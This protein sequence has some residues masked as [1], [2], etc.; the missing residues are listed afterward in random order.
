MMP[1]L[2]AFCIQAISKQGCSSSCARTAQREEGELPL[3]HPGSYKKAQGTGLS[4]SGSEELRSTLLPRS[5]L[6]A[7]SN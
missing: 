3:G 7:D 4:R 6:V 2:S 5:G 1:T